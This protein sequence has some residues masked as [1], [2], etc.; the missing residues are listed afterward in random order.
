[1]PGAK[2]YLYIKK[3]IE[4]VKI[5]LIMCFNRTNFLPVNK[6]KQILLILK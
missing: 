4:K 3:D 6:Y 1:M 2:I 5:L